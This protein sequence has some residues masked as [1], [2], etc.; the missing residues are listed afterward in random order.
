MNDLESCIEGKIS[1]VHGIDINIFQECMEIQNGVLTNDENKVN[2]HI[3][4]VMQF[5]HLA[6]Q[7]EKQKVRKETSYEFI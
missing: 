7:L 6:E 1:I 5:V 2:L 4:L 3:E